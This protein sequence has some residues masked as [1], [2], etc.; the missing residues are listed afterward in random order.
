[1]SYTI[2]LLEKKVK[3]YKSRWRHVAALL[4]K[5]EKRERELVEIIRKYDPKFEKPLFS[6]V[7]MNNYLED[8]FEAAVRASEP[9]IKVVGRLSGDVNVTTK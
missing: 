4:R 9:G 6:P 5:Q 7:V 8:E 1:M 3:K 2:K